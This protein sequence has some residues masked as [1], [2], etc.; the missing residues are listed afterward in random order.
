M[1]KSSS[2]SAASDF[3]EQAENE[4]SG[5]FFLGNRKLLGL[6]GIGLLLLVAAISYFAYVRGASSD[7]AQIELARIRPYYDRGE[8]AVA[9]GGDS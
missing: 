4:Q 3:P 8:Y 1:A 5:G 6:I 2:Q 9:I 7:R